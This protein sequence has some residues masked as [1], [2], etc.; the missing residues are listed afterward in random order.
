MTEN[1]IGAVTRARFPVRTRESNFENVAVAASFVQ[2][3]HP[4]AKILQRLPINPYRNT[5]ISAK[6]ISAETLSFVEPNVTTRTKRS[7][8]KPLR[9]QCRGARGR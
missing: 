9:L 3:S 1:V 4:R 6:T 5:Q 7:A 8:Q 2:N